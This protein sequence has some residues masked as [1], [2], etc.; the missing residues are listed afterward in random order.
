MLP[1]PPPLVLE[2]ALTDKSVEGGGEFGEPLPNLYFPSPPLLKLL[3]SCSNSTSSLRIKQRAQSTKGKKINKDDEPKMGGGETQTDEA[4]R[5]KTNEDPII[6]DQQSAALS[7][8]LF[9]SFGLFVCSLDHLLLVADATA[10]ALVF[11]V[12]KLRTDNEFGE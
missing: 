8:P 10:A 3:L 7:L 6:A 4:T 2:Y 9:S 5:L 1:P 12:H 11:L